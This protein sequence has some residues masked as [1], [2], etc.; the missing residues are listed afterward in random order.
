MKKW[1]A[2]NSTCL[3]LRNLEHQANPSSVEHL[4]QRER[5]R[6]TLRRVFLTALGGDIRKAINHYKC[7]EECRGRGYRK[8][9]VWS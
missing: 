6:E 8:D 7:L 9:E 3:S 2:V 1:S 4:Q 5:Q